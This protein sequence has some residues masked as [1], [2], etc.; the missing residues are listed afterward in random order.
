MTPKETPKNPGKEQ[1]LSGF[2]KER[3][4]AYREQAMKLFPKIC[5]RCGRE[6]SGKR[7]RELTVHHKD[8]N[9]NNNPPDGSNW[10]LLCLFCHDHEHSKYLDAEWL[11]EETPR[12]RREPT[13]TYQPFAALGSLLKKKE[14]A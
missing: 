5:A 2:G 9:H 14:E 1:I 3:E 13:S 6:F 11:D 8:H 4:K 12:D 7:L 10:E